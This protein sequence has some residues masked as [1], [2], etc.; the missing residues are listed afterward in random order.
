MRQEEGGPMPHSDEQSHQTSSVLRHFHTE[1]SPQLTFTGKFGTMYSTVSPLARAVIVVK[2]QH[3]RN[4][5]APHF[6][7]F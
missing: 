3:H 2:S 7:P 6:P 5:R 1:V 4:T